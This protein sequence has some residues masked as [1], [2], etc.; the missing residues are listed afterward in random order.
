MDDPVLMTGSEGQVGRT[1][2]DRL[3]E[4]Y[5]WRLLDRHPPTG[6]W[7]AERIV[8]DVTDD[9]VVREAMAGCGAVVHL[10][11]DPRPSAQWDS[12]VS[13]NIDG[14][15]TV[16]EAAVAADV[17]K[18]VFASSNHVVGHHETDR[19]PDLYSRDS[20]VELDR[21]DCPRPG[22]L[23][24]VSKATGELLGRYYH[25]EHDVSFIGVRIGNLTGAGPPEGYP[26]GRAMW[27]SARD[28][29]HLFERC[30][31]AEYGF[32]IVYG[33]SDNATKFYS[34]DRA[35]EILEYEPKDDSATW[36]E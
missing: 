16:L 23:Y 2:L 26:R 27:L 5:E 32:E 35:R 34:L 1:I 11:G 12:V 29:A 3:S 20:T 19:Q 30:L 4:E 14:T 25:D 13:N 8:G 36:E 15:N 9:E 21:T 10:A 22:N 24:G 33:I 17:E 6:D 7:A 31:E 28:C 18:V